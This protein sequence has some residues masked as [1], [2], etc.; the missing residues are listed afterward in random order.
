MHGFGNVAVYAGAFFDFAD[1]EGL[2]GDGAFDSFEVELGKYDQFVEGN[3]GFFHFDVDEGGLISLHLHFGRQGGFKTD[4]AGGQSDESGFDAGKDEVSVQIGCGADG[5]SLYLDV[6]EFDGFVGFGVDYAPF[7]GSFLSEQRGCGKKEKGGENVF[8]HTG[9]V[10]FIMSRKEGVWKV[11]GVCFGGQ[12]GKKGP[13]FQRGVPGALSFVP[14][15]GISACFRADG[16]IRKG[17][18]SV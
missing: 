5:C 12:V 16:F 15:E 13:V 7:D 18:I 17:A 10:F 14:E 8:F 6:Y 2:Y 11:K 1:S 4:Q 3:G 9:N